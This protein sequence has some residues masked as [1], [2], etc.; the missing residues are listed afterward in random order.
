MRSAGRSSIGHERADPILRH[1]LSVSYTPPFPY[2]SL[3]PA[4]EPPPVPPGV[5]L[6]LDGLRLGGPPLPPPP[7][8]CAP[9]G[10]IRPPEPQPTRPF[11]P[12]GAGPQPVGCL[13]GG[14][15]RRG[16]A[17][18]VC[19][20]CC[21]PVTC[22]APYPWPHLRAAGGPVRCFAPPPLPPP[23]SPRYA[24]APG[25][26]RGPSPSSPPPPPSVVSPLPADPL[27]N[28]R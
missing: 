7:F 23:P 22:P 2:R 16:C 3:P 24:R 12:S 21:R 14:R 11:T 19:A 4:A 13:R 20:I 17:R 10:A 28:D 26:R 25:G 9:A 1:L 8:S 15:P 6:R 5:A 27:A 18:L